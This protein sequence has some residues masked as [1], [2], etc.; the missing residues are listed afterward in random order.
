MQFSSCGNTI[1]IIENVSEFTAE[2]SACH[3]AYKCLFAFSFYAKTTYFF[4]PLNT[5][6]KVGILDLVTL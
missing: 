2:F 4:V 5:Q 3:F 1:L 6:T